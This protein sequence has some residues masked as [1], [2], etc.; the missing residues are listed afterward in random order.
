MKVLSAAFTSFLCF[1]TA[2]SISSDMDFLPILL[3]IAAFTYSGA[4]N[5][6]EGR[7]FLMH[8]PDA[9]GN[10]QLSIVASTRDVPPINP[11]EDVTFF[12]YTRRGSSQLY[13]GNSTLL[14]ESTFNASLPTRLVTHG[15]R[16]TVESST[17][18]DIKN[19]YLDVEDCNVVGID[20]SG[21]ADNIMYGTVK[22]QTKQIGPFVAKFIDF[23]VEETKMNLANVHLSGHSLGAHVMG[24]TGKSV[25]TGKV[26]RITG[27]DPAG[28]LYTVEND[29]ERL[30]VGDAE[31]VDI[32]H[33]CG[34]LLGF[35]EPI[36]DV[37]FFP[38]VGACSHSRAWKYFAESI[39]TDAFQSLPCD[40]YDNFKAGKCDNEPKVPMGEYAP[41][42]IRGTYF[43]DTSSSPPYALG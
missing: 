35:K 34:G 14:H 1:P 7:A 8:F 19:M 41:S 10:A 17:V 24:L 26:G 4:E 43:L 11:E 18:Q 42:N 23:L 37:D 5:A 16:D 13:V 21:I 40:S 27:I 9:K 28:V 36:G 32:I 2:S 29:S 31:F 22:E 20:W 12:L 15:Y 38:N 33:A 3:C 30:A 25:Q 6:S 39:G